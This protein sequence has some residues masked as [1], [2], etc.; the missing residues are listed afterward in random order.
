MKKNGYQN[1]E[2]TM[3]GAFQH[4][5]TGVSAIIKKFTGVAK[6]Q[7]CYADGTHYDTVYC[8]NRGYNVYGIMIGVIKACNDGKPRYESNWA[9]D[10]NNRVWR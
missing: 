4:K 6:I 8:D 10:V 7:V 9:N 3:K 2:R 5:E 1:L